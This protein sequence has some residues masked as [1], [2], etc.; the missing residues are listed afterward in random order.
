VIAELPGC[1]NNPNDP[2]RRSQPVRLIA[3]MVAAKICCMVGSAAFASTLVELAGLWHLDSTRA[4]WVS[5]AYLLGYALAVP[6]LV[7]LTDRV[8]ACSVY[9]SGCI[10]T[11]TLQVGMLDSSLLLN[12][13]GLIR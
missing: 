5:G 10:I 13:Q 11:Q 6:L 3:G 9:I 8:D 12:F 2:E 7:G 4:G 1:D